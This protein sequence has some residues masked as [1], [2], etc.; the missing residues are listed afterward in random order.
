MATEV[1]MPQMGESIFEGTITKWLKKVGDTVQKDEPLFEISTDKVD[2]E[3]PSPVAGVLSEIKV[4][5]GA[6]VQINTV[7]A[8]VGE[9]AAPQKEAPA[10]A[11]K[12]ATAPAS[13][14][15]AGDGASDAA[16]AAAKST[17]Q[18]DASGPVSAGPV[19]GGTDVVMPQMGESIFEGTITK[20]LKKVGDSV[21]KD[22]P[23]FEI[24]TDKVDAEIPAPV[25]GKL[26]EIKVP[27]GA[28]V[29][30]NTVVAV[31]GGSSASPA[32]AT[33][34]PVSAPAKSEAPAASP[35]TAP[36]PASA[37]TA[38]RLRSSP[39]VRRIAKDNNLDLTQIPGTGSGGR[40]TKDDTL[41]FLA[42]KGA[43]AT[44]PAPAPIPATP[45]AVPVAA[46][47]AASAP[48]I[49]AAAPIAPAASPLPGEL[50][51]LT[52]MRS[53]IAQRMVESAHTSPHVHTVFKVDMTR[54]A[55]LREKEKGKYEQRNG[56]K[57]TYMPFIAAAA[58]QT[59]RKFPIVNASMEG[60]AIR[61]HQNINL[62]IAVSLEWGLIVPV[63]KQA[64]E[65]SFLGLA[66][67]VADLA[68]RARGK[69]LKPEEVSGST[70]TLTNSGIFGEEFGTPIINQPD[71][72]ILAIGGLKK[73]PLVITDSEGNDT[74]AI[75]WTQNFCLG[76]D[77]RTIDGADAGKFM[78]EFKKTL[79]N[80]S[81]DIG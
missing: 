62:G 69:K 74:I 32:T 72:A 6:T 46:P 23:L 9:A 78:A 33:A 29:Q 5:E 68:E 26:S 36:I 15:A 52:R 21:A 42:E 44:A 30:I 60:D 12:P 14:S 80:W 76:F 57:L 49:A 37:G 34:A 27:E 81:G 35:M 71:S 51:P 45:P 39:L 64:E 25:A 18:P 50:V 61:Y 73:E 66:R 19:S 53:I 63:I 3:I 22:E 56:V 79:E 20:W 43:G 75:R 8:L 58:V 10:A 1:I 38:E 24:S 13:K 70:F 54:I 55:K 47:V 31:I 59:L 2:A 28:T 17:A 48:A 16:N 4:F 7:V 11:S 40:I 65:R 67:A 41:K 77:H